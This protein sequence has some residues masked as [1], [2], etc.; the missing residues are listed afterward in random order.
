MPD[1]FLQSLSGFVSECSAT[2]KSSV[3]LLLASR[4]ATIGCSS[5]YRRPLIV[6]GN[7]PSLKDNLLNDMDTLR[8]HP[9][10]A[11]NFFANS[12]EFS[13]VRPRYYVLAD[14]HFFTG[15]D[16]DENVSRL[17]ANIRS[18]SW[19]MI[20]FIPASFR[21][22][23]AAFNGSKIEIRFFNAVAMEGFRW[24]EHLAWSR[25]LGMPRPRNVLIPSLMIGL[26]LGFKTI[27][28]L[29]A[30]HSWTRTLSVTDDN[31]VVSVQPH[32]YA[33][34]AGE[35]E[36][37]SSVYAGVRLHQVMESM[38]IAFRSYH[39]IRRYAAHIGAQIFNATPGSM[40]DAFPRQQLPPAQS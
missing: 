33:D 1:G 14:P 40:I 23:A 19:T 13:I 25:N 36:R 32:F 37:V 15:G 18:A 27:Y 11:V 9:A 4:R 16:S 39:D 35:K 26:S 29:G 10:L 6:L 8:E 7:G 3:K 34:S 20:L 21:R 24:F 28:L 17:A 12:P 38:V 22:H 2:L 30:D 5:E 31:T